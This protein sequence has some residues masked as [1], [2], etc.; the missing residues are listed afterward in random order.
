MRKVVIIVLVILV[1]SGAIG[2]IPLT[3]SPDNQ[4]YLYTT[5]NSIPTNPTSGDFAFVSIF[6]VGSN[7]SSLGWK[8]TSG[9]QPV[10]TSS[11]MSGGQPS[12][13]L[14]QGS[15]IA[16]SRSFPPGDRLLS[17][18]F[19]VKAWS[20]TFVFS[21]VNSSLQNILSIS[22]QAASLS[23]ISGNE[24][25]RIGI[26]GSAA[27]SGGWLLIQG[28]TFENIS[29]SNGS[30]NLELFSGGN[31]VPLANISIRDMSSYSGLTVSSL[32]GSAYLSDVIFTSDPIALTLP[33]YNIM[34]G[35][36]QGSGDIAQLL[37]PFTVL[38][39]DI[40][41]YNWSSAS[42]G[43]M[44]LQINALNYS[45]SLNPTAKG[46]FQVGIDLD[47][48]GSIA[49]WYVSGTNA[50]AVYFPNFYN[51]DFMPGIQSPNGTRLSL[52]I[53]YLTARHLVLMQVIDYSV[54]RQFEF[55]NASV[56]YSG[57]PFYS[58]YT[59]LELSS[60]VSPDKYSG[61][62]LIYNITYGNSLESMQPFAP[63]YELPYS[64]NAP[65]NWHIG[66]YNFT[67]NGYSESL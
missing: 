61:H 9:D 21:I 38:R 24:T 5:E 62:F 32:N 4:S 8:L 19:A 67:I 47:P 58:A 14:P 42:F 65:S 49:P 64:I 15:E 7:Y 37:G 63:D 13:F 17:F 36:G 51:P 22:L 48:A 57:P 44:S 11:K 66:P 52:S 53:E 2:I 54:G 30:W 6:S 3:L 29:T 56:Q 41:L 20:G 39:A 35:Y 59:Q 16:S 23:A 60:S 46:F 27:E 43:A 18:Q 31:D 33:G 45:A 50:I 1:A 34:E 55:W 26:Q 28:T 40:I 12:L 10:V 25:K